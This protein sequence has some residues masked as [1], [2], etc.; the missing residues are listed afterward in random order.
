ME[1]RKVTQLNKLFEKMVSNDANTSE[2]SEL[3]NLYQEF[4]NDGREG[5][6]NKKPNN[7]SIHQSAAV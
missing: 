6:F 4:I 7:Q 1:Q 3:N 2:R 5:H